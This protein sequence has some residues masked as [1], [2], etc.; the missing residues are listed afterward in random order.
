VGVA[1]TATPS[2]YRCLEDDSDGGNNHSHNHKTAVD[3]R[4]RKPEESATGF[5][6]SGYVRL[7][8]PHDDDSETWA[9]DTAALVSTPIGTWKLDPSDS[10]GISLSADTTFLPT[11]Y[12][13][14][15]GNTE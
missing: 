11:F 5:T 3:K 15:H 12:L 8:P 6:D 13:N 10:L 7:C 4:R 14:Q 9:T 1:A 2:P